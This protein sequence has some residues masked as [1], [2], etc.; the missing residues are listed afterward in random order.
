MGPWNGTNPGIAFV[1]RGPR[2]VKRAVKHPGARAHVHVRAYSNSVYAL[3]RR[4]RVG[5]RSLRNA[6]SSI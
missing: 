5:W 1:A 2:A 6:F 3:S 4:E